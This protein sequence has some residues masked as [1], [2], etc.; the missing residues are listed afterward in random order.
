MQLHF[1][2]HL[3]FA[4]AILA[5]PVSTEASIRALL[6]KLHKSI[7]LQMQSVKSQEFFTPL[8]LEG[9]KTIALLKN[10]LAAFTGD[11]A[12]KAKLQKYADTYYQFAENVQIDHAV[13]ITTAAPS[14]PPLAR[15]NGF[16]KL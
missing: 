10:D 11:P 2:F 3:L 8:A 12:V 15:Q 7:Q 6:D 14:R 16:T 9:E 5:V 13:S 4:S 1:I